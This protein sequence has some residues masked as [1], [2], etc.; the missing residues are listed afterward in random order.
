MFEAV[1][2]VVKML[3]V[4]QQK[5]KFDFTWLLLSGFQKLCDKDLQKH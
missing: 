5:L 3:I 1:V 2:L 4:F